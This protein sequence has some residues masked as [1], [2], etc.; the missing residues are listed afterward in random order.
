MIVYGRNPVRE[1]LRGRRAA[2]VSDVWATAGAS[3]EPWIHGLE[4]RI[5]SAEEI[6]R[7]SGSSAHQGICA[8]AG[9]YPYAA[10]DRLLAG[11]E[12]LIVALDQVQDPQNL[13][14]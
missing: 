8:H 11:H 3:R 9:P 5:V 13:G 14:S 10:A 6:E 1:A 2:S 7:R 4:P 12:P